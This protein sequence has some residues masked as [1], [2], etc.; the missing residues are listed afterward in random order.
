MEEVWSRTVGLLIAFSGKERPH[1][2]GEH[3]PFGQPNHP[4]R[5]GATQSLRHVPLETKIHSGKLREKS[6]QGDYTLPNR[7]F[8]ILIRQCRYVSS[9]TTC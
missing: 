7:M 5:D 2:G 9:S 1:N 6:G 4:T 8:Y 3:F